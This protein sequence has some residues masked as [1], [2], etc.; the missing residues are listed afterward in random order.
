MKVET[1]GMLLEA[2]TL[3]ETAKKCLS[4]DN[5]IEVFE[6]VSKL[7]EAYVFKYRFKRPADIVSKVLRK[8]TEGQ[9][10][11][12]RLAEANSIVPP[13]TSIGDQRLVNLDKAVRVEFEQAFKNTCYDF[14]HLD[15][16]LGCRF[17]TLYQAGIP[18]TV[19]LLLS[20]IEDFN[21]KRLKSVFP[22]KMKEFVI[23]SNRL[24]NDPLSITDET[25]QIVERSK[26]MV[27][28]DRMTNIRP[29]ESKKSAYSSVHFVF[30]RNL[31][32]DGSDKY[33]IGVPLATVSFEVQIRDIFGEGWGEIQHH[34]LYS[35]KDRS[36][37]PADAQKLWSPH[38]NALKT[39]VDGCSQHASIIW[40]SKTAN[41]SAELGN[42]EDRSF[43]ERSLDYESILHASK[44][45][46]KEE[47]EKL[48]VAYAQLIGVERDKDAVSRVLKYASVVENL[49]A[50]LENAAAPVINSSVAEFPKRTVGYFLQMEL[51]NSCYAIVSGLKNLTEFEV[52]GSKDVLPTDGK[53]FERAITNL[54]Y[55]RAQYPRDAAA[56]FR[57]A[58]CKMLSARSRSD[59]QDVRTLTELV[60]TFSDSDD[61]LPK[62][63]WI[64]SAAKL[65]MGAAFRKEAMLLEAS[66]DEARELFDKAMDATFASVKAAREY[67]MNEPGSIAAEYEHRALSN[68]LYYI[69]EFG[70]KYPANKDRCVQKL[71]DTVGDYSKLGHV[72][73]PEAFRSADNLSMA[74]SFLGRHED[75][76]RIASS[77]Y[78]ELRSECEIRAGYP[79]V[80]D[81][82]L[83]KHLRPRERPS[84]LAAKAIL[85]D[86]K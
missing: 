38:L 62:R 20:K 55:V 5:L 28:L 24:P 85:S 10:T 2:T 32:V 67:G 56:A 40:K 61:V 76:K 82:F 69:A 26:Q 11:L 54:E 16:S 64:V 25:Y 33:E 70:E 81:A 49:Q 17:V 13:P 65:T 50:I 35:E 44:G 29:P 22:V 47:L 37:P 42:P 14:R 73:Y 15:D 12:E 83:T 45:A 7:P 6:E 34:L 18:R 74:L 77:V 51:A 80:D 36:E 75:A 79:L 63:H 72:V 84:F 78:T 60:V 9:K 39:F 66:T 4:M 59:F 27:A 86:V 8:R 71:E 68:C 43:T 21:K 23:Y 1:Q 41:E 52:N 53:F 3:H 57:L 58:R 46:E 30:E 19:E 31:P 48:T